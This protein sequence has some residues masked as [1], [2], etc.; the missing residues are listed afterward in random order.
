[1]D[2]SKRFSQGVREQVVRLVV[3]IEK[4]HSSQW[5]AIC[6]AGDLP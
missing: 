6:S 4:D 5:S 3:E 2:R 1:M